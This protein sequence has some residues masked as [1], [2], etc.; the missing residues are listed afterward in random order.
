[1]YALY[2]YVHMIQVCMYVHIYMGLW[3]YNY[4]P[5]S[6]LVSLKQLISVSLYVIL[7]NS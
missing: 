7:I 6:L 1:M 3:V 4:V 2:M 5:G